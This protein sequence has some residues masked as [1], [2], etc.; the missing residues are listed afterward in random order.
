MKDDLLPLVPF[1]LALI[2]RSHDFKDINKALTP[3]ND[4]TRLNLELNFC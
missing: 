3:T 4:R 1:K 2:I